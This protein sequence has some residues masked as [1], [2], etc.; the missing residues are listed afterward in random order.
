M[1]YFVVFIVVHCVIDVDI[2][3]VRFFG[4]FGVAEEGAGTEAQADQEVEVEEEADT[5]G[6][7][8][9]SMFIAACMGDL[10]DFRKRLQIG[11]RF[12]VGLGLAL[13]C[14][15]LLRLLRSIMSCVTMSI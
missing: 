7:G 12:D 6:A 3:H 14:L 8:Y 2:S 10:A 4:G 1:Q 5:E 13:F 9:A 11:T 15:S